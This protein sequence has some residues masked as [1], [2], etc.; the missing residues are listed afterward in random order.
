[1]L[2]WLKPKAMS[3]SLLTRTKFMQI[4]EIYINAVQISHYIK[5]NTQT[6]PSLA[7]LETVL[8]KQKPRAGENAN[9]YLFN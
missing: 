9:L 5:R 6:Q 3:L 4:Q 1:C 7:K 8:T 2:L